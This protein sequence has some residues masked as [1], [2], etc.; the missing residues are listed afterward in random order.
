MQKCQ[1]NGPNGG[2]M[3]DKLGLGPEVRDL[4]L[5]PS[6]SNKGTAFHTIRYDFKP[7]SVDVSKMATVDMG[8]KGSV[9]VTV[10]HL[11]GAGTPHTVFK[12]SQKPYNKECVLIIDRNTGE[13]TLEKLSCNIQVKKTRM[14]TAHRLAP[15][16]LGSETNSSSGTG[17]KRSPHQKAAHSSAL[18]P[19][20]VP[21][22]SPLHASPSRRSPTTS[23]L[24]ASIPPSRSP[25][26]SRRMSPS[27]SI[28][29]LSSAVAN[30]H[31]PA[32]QKSPSLASL[33]IIGSDEPITASQEMSVDNDFDSAKDV[34]PVGVLSDSSSDSN[35]S[36]ES[37][38]SDSESEP[39]HS[40]LT[41]M[42]LNGHMNG[43]TRL[44]SPLP[45]NNNTSN[46]N[47]MQQHEHLLT[48]DL[49]LSESGSDSD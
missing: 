48:E 46:S 49:Q 12:G 37:G 42:S 19:L 24:A 21:R 35:S 6:F 16:A 36:S 38:S 32:N 39:D 29:A 17:G 45:A 44:C 14:E 31:A 22:H 20:T 15:P 30:T 3:A 34:P 41:A 13:I 33:P 25:P 5:G 9:T 4:K 27:H 18:P 40:R 10:P 28:P 2:S 1:L 8:Q 43:M 26:T 47:S 23:S 7:A 11:D